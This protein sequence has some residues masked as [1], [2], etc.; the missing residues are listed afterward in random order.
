[1]TT[2]GAITSTAT[3]TAATFNSTSDYNLKEN[4]IYLNEEYELNKLKPCTFN[5]KNS[6]T[7]QLGFIAQDV[8]EIIPL[9]ISDNASILSID[10]S[11]IIAASVITIKKLTERVEI[12]ESILN[13]Y[14]LI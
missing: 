1:L 4:I 7:T 8:R 3:I 10:Y 12:L 11:G 14:N 2:S 9:S 6:S 13:K 5:F